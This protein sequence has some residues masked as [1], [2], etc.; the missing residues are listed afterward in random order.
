MKHYI[1]LLLLTFSSNFMLASSPICDIDSSFSKLKYSETKANK[2][3]T[4]YVKVTSPTCV[5]ARHVI[6]LKKDKDL[7]SFF[8]FEI[9][10]EIQDSTD[11]NN[12]CTSYISYQG[13]YL[14]V[15]YG[16]PSKNFLISLQPV[17]NDMIRDKKI[18]DQGKD[19]IKSVVKLKNKE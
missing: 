1:F 2:K 3:F 13:V 16:I 18:M 9:L 19:S 15:I 12:E 10:T 14:G 5:G 11:Q 7:F 8:E 4:L 17:F 6:N